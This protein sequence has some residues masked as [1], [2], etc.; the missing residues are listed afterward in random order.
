[1]PLIFHSRWLKKSFSLSGVTYGLISF[2]P[3]LHFHLAECRETYKGGF[4]SSYP[5]PASHSKL[6]GEPFKDMGKLKIEGKLVQIKICMYVCT[7]E[8]KYVWKQYR[9]PHWVP[10]GSVL[11]PVLFNL[12][13]Q[14]SQ[15][16]VHIIH[17]LTNNCPIIALS[18]GVEGLSSFGFSF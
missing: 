3:D 17:L 18:T 9:I 5:R 11:G 12:F 2:Q 10:Q 16:T 4:V 14:F 7:F 6:D 15:L 13:N 8:C 1:M